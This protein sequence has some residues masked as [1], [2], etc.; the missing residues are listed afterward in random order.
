MN[1]TLHL[2]LMNCTAEEKEIKIGTNFSEGNLIPSCR[3]TAYK[4]LVSLQCIFQPCALVSILL[5]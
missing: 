1:F 4:V 5:K 2:M 3:L